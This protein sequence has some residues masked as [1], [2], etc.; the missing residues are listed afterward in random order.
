MALA[1]WA[2]WRPGIAQKVLA[3]ALI[4]VGLAPSIVALWNLATVPVID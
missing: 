2:V 3:F 4:L 1:T